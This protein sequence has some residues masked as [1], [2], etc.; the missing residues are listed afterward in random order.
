M[1]EWV[2][3]IDNIGE[4]GK[5]TAKQTCTQDDMASE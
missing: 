5:W 1:N 2:D 3:E 4:V